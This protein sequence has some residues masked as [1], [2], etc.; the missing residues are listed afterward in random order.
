M[1]M[2]GPT[3]NARTACEAVLRSLPQWFGIEE[4]LLMYADDTLRLPSFAALEGDEIVGFVSLMEHFPQAWEIHCIAVRAA[5][6]NAGIGRALVAHTEAWL[7]AKQV[8]LLQVKTIAATSPSPAYAQT[9]EFYCRA[10]FLPLEV[11]PLLWSPRNPC[12]QLVKFLPEGGA[13][14]A[15]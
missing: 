7:A 10:G 4:S 14:R 1:Q 2:I 5:S 9:R 11:F 15:S 3:L 6:R 13:E 8:T 12:L